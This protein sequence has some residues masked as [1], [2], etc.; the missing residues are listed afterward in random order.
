MGPSELRSQARF[1][2]QV[3]GSQDELWVTEESD[4]TKGSQSLIRSP[5]SVG[6]AWSSAP[7]FNAPV[8]PVPAA[9]LLALGNRRCQIQ[10]WR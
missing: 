7:V 8:G 1:P 6:V 10:L 4:E 5:L 3:G 2:E 9:A